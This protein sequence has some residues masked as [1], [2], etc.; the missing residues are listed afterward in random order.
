MIKIML[1]DGYYYDEMLI[2]Q[3]EQWLYYNVWW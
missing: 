3:G 1:F 2:V